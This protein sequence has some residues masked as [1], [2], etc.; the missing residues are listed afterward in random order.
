MNSFEA[1]KDMKRMININ[2]IEDV[3]IK[4]YSEKC[5]SGYSEQMLTSFEGLIDG[6]VCFK[7]QKDTSNKLYYTAQHRVS[8][9]KCEYQS[10]CYDLPT[11]IYGKKT[12]NLKV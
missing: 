8:E 6:C 2:P 4:K 1:I 11:Q 9:S 12:K 10:T 5:D 7:M 3:K